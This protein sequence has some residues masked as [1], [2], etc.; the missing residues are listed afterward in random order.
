MKNK[1][2]LWTALPFLAGAIFGISLLGLLSFTGQPKSANAD[3]VVTKISVTDAH[4]YFQNYYKNAIAYTSKMK[5]F[6]VD[7]EDLTAMNIIMGATPSAVGFRV[8]FGNDTSG[9]PLLIICGV[10]ANGYD[11]TGN[12]YSAT[13]NRVGPCPPVCDLTSPISQ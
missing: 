1:K 7:K 6:I 2:I 9:A 8:Y 3:P 5:G 11:M 4:T 12:V 13:T 10:D